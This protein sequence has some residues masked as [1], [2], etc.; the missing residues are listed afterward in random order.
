MAFGLMGRGL[1]RFSEEADVEVVLGIVEVD[2]VQIVCVCAATDGCALG[3]GCEWARKA[4]RKVERKGRWV[5]MVQ[6]M[7]GA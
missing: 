3:C 5:G 1:A 4:A 6:D 7:L 2:E